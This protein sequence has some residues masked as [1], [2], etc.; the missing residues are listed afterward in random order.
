VD[1]GCSLLEERPATDQR[2]WLSRFGQS[3]R[4]DLRGGEEAPLDVGGDA[5]GGARGRL[6]LVAGVE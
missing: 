4:G 1:D 2:R 5:L 3:E 6:P